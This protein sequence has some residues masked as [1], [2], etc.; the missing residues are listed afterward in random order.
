[1][2]AAKVVD[3]SA[4]V[5]VLFG[6]PD[7]DRVAERLEGGRL[8]APPLLEYEISNVCVVKCRR[9]PADRAAILAAFSKRALFGIQ[10]VG[11]DSEALT[12]VALDS[13]LTAYDASYLLLSQELGAELVTLDE[14]LGR[15]ASVVVR[16]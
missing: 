1:M 15:A 13:G 9:H 4:L 3:A 14:A 10:E 6:E 8:F 11:V 5:A 16:R 12:T 7:A 2:T